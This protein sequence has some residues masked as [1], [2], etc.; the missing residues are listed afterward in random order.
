MAVNQIRI[1]NFVLLL[2]NE[3]Q[4]YEKNYTRPYDVMPVGFGIGTTAGKTL[5]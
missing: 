4:K 1:P 5:Q 3:Q 2:T